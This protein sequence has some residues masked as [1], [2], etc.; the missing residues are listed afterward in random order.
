MPSINEVGAPNA[1][2]ISGNDAKDLLKVAAAKAAAR[3]L[4]VQLVFE[5]LDANI[6][7]YVAY[8]PTEHHISREDAKDPALYRRA[9]AI[10]EE[11]H[12]R[13]IIDPAMEIPPAVRDASTVLIPRGAD[14]ATYKRMKA[15][16][17]AR[18]VPYWIAD[19]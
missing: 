16:A 14:H 19:E 13:L 9:K 7:A 2:R 4:K 11:M 6:P 8:D 10:A 5:D 3:E 15:D 18:G 17:E 1:I 12:A